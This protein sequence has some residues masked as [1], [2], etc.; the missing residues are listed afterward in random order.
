MNEEQFLQWMTAYTEALQ[1]HKELLTQLDSQIG[2]GDHGTN[3]VR[4][5]QA[6]MTKLQSAP[7]GDIGGAAKLISSTLIST[8]GGSSGPLYGTFFLKLAIVL[9]H[10]PSCTVAELLEG[11]E[12]GC[13]G[14]QMLGKAQQGD[15][16]MLDVF[17]P[18]LTA[19][20]QSAEAGGEL[21]GC[22]AAAEHAAEEG[23]KATIPIV[24]K[25][26][27]ASY[28]GARSA[29]HQDPGATSAYL[30]FKTAAAVFSNQA[31]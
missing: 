17:L 28:L 29:G 13:L 30:L 18:A 15:K 21:G 20:R 24:A 8:V 5:F 12:K 6:V 7:A 10:K 11:M 26:G 9:A 23:M 1:A 3:M 19:F 27:R 22:F 14:I 4:G 16:T 2:D 31:A 25:K